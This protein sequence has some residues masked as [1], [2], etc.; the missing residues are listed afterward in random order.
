MPSHRLHPRAV[1]TVLV[2]LCLAVCAAPA[3]FASDH[4][5]DTIVGYRFASP[6]RAMQSP[7][8]SVVGLRL[9]PDPH[10]TVKPDAP[11]DGRKASRDGGDNLAAGLVAAAIVLVLV[12]PFAL[13]ARV[14]PVAPV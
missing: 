7:G 6:D 9:I 12:A 13:T 4:S 5:G 3:A 1:A 10:A 14:R 11:I 2:A 8:G